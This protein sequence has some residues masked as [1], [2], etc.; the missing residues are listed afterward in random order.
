MLDT[1]IV[2]WIGLSV[3]RIEST[4]RVYAKYS[5]MQNDMVTTVISMFGQG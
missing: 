2:M 5:V 4:S 3:L 1:G